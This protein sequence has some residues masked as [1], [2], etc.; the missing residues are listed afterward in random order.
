MEAFLLD[1]VF[2]EDDFL[3]Q[4]KSVEMS[5]TMSFTDT[6]DTHRYSADAT[7]RLTFDDTLSYTGSVRH[8]T[9]SD[10]IVWQEEIGRNVNIVSLY[11][12]LYLIDYF[13]RPDPAH[14]LDDELLFLDSISVDSGPALSDVLV[15]AETLTCHTVTIRPVTDSLVLDDGF[16]AYLNNPWTPIFPIVEPQHP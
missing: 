15:F 1:F 9:L 14:T 5:D 11:D 13:P 3:S 2:F 7:D 6:M 10:E 16:C 4:S 8:F 12:Q